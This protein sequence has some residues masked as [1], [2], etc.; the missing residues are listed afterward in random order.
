MS[1]VM[2]ATAVLPDHSCKI[3]E[4]CGYR[5]QPNGDGAPYAHN[6]SSISDNDIA[7]G[8]IHAAK[9]FSNSTLCDF[10]YCG[11]DADGTASVS[12]GSG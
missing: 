10:I 11:Q 4:H 7:A 3:R 9:K 8:W 1:M 6:D 5:E 12:N 2:A